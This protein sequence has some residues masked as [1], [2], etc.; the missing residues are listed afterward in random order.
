MLDPE[1]VRL[2][3]SIG[4]GPRRPHL[5]LQGIDSFGRLFRLRLVPL[6]LVTELRAPGEQAVDLGT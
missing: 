4:R 1:P 3:G 2:D 5:R 6:N